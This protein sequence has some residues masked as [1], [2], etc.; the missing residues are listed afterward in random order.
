MGNNFRLG[1]HS[2]TLSRQTMRDLWGLQPGKEEVPVSAGR[3]I[4][5]A[6]SLLYHPEWTGLGFGFDSGGTLFWQPDAPGSGPA[7]DLWMQCP[8]TDDELRADLGWDFT[9]DVADT[10]SRDKAHIQGLMNRYLNWAATGRF[11]SRLVLWTVFFGSDT[12]IAD[13]G[14]DPG[15]YPPFPI[16]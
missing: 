15:Y 13:A 2:A 4:S 5:Y 9:Q 11:P 8:Q 16:P 7:I 10:Q 1:F 3:L 12:Q 14:Y 6:Q